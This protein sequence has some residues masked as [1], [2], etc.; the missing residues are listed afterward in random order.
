[1]DSISKFMLSGVENQVG[2]MGQPLVASDERPHVSDPL[3]GGPDEDLPENSAERSSSKRGRFVMSHLIMDH[4]GSGCFGNQTGVSYRLTAGGVGFIGMISLIGPMS[5]PLLYFIEQS[6]RGSN[7]IL[8]F[9]YL[10]TSPI[11][12][13]NHLSHI[14]EHGCRFIQNH[15]QQNTHNAQNAQNDQDAHYA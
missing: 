12:L 2:W 14:I 11:Q 10:L 1:M 6:V 15:Q 13:L 7:Q 8:T 5:F 9:F 3:L 4:G